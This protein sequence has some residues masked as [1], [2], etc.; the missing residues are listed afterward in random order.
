MKIHN[1]KQIEDSVQI[2]STLT[3][4]V[5]IVSTLHLAIAKLII[6]KL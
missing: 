3:L 1:R 2:N 6:C 5:D 4:L